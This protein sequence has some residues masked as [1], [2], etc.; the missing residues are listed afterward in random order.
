MLMIDMVKGIL[1]K[2]DLFMEFLKGYGD[3]FD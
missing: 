1:N 3:D 2:R